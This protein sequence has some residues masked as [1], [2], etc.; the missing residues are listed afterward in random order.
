MVKNDAA[1]DNIVDLSQVFAECKKEIFLDECHMNDFGN[2]IV[3]TEITN[4]IHR[5]NLL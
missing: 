1:Q 2:E 3:A 4:L 5:G